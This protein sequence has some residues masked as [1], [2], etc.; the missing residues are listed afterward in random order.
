MGSFSE[1]G[2]VIS[3]YVCAK[4]APPNQRVYDVP[5]NKALAYFMFCTGGADW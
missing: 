4:I 5:T 3:S 1:A 2:I